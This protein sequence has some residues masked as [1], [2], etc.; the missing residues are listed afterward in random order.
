MKTIAKKQEMQKV[1]VMLPRD[2]V[3][4]AKR[5]SGLGITPA[6]RKGLEAVAATEAY[7]ALLRLRG[8]EPSS[9]GWKELRRD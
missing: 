5:A 3:E 1:T 6:I 7:E 4:R 2:L 9:I 8:K